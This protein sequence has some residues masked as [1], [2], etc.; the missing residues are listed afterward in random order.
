VGEVSL[1]EAR[2]ALK[3]AREQLERVQVAGI[4]P[5]D[6]VEAVTFAFYAYENGVVAVAEVKGIEW[7]KN[8]YE[9][10]KLARTL[11][12]KK[13]LSTDIEDQLLRLNDLRK[14][15]AYGE[16]G[17]EL[18]QLDLEDLASD[19]ERFLDEVETV[20]EG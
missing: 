20:V 4:E 2:A 6:H 14:D 10:A 12:D 16:P 5:L 19:L 18:E 13:F 1:T 17:L 7:T 11:F 15:V 9:K 8:H 3:R